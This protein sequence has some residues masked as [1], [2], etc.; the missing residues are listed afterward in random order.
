[1]QDA[2]GKENNVKEI[3]KEI[4]KIHG[5]MVVLYKV[6]IIPTIPWNFARLGF[7]LN[8]DDLSG[9]LTVNSAT[10]LTK[11]RFLRLV[12]ENESH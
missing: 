12:L 7:G 8:P 11:S 10:V 3:K 2:L 9:L 4:L 1:M 6:T 5:A